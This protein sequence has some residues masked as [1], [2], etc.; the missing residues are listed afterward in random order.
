ME[1]QNMFV[2]IMSWTAV[3]L[4]STSYWFQIW[5]IHVHKEVRDLSMT[6]HVF[7]ALGFG[8]L[9]YTAWV[10][11]SLI[12]LI[13]QIATTIPVVVI[14][15][16]IIIHKEDHWH[17]ENDPYC[18]SCKNELEQDWKHCPYCGTPRPEPAM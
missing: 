6:Y 5:K 15:A 3:V 13:K 8:I 7:L 9:T 17:D 16:Q 10:E 18:T 11:D 4:L 2:E 14:I 1:D 12:F